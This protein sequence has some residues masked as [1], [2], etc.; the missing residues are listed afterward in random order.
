MKRVVWG[1]GGLAG[2]GGAVVVGALAWGGE[3]LI[4]FPSMPSSYEAKEYCSCR[5][6]SRREASFCDAFVHQDV[7]PTQGRTVD[8]EAKTVTATALWVSN[9]ARWVD[10]RQGCVIED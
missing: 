10:A 3:A 1:L 5:F 7:V 4:D 9:T 6:V 8:E 2:L